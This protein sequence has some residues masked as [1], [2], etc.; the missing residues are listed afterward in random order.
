[1]EKNMLSNI[2][3]SW[4]AGQFVALFHLE[5]S[6]ELAASETCILL[7]YALVLDVIFIK[8]AAS[9]KDR[10]LQFAGKRTNLML[11]IIIPFISYIAVFFCGV[12]MRIIEF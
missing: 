4:I 12:L 1:M 2:Y 11:N 5:L 10:V 6:F 3:V 7:V 8:A 9:N